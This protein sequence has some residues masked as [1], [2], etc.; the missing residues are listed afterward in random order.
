MQ[1]TT[2]LSDRG[3]RAGGSRELPPDL[4]QPAESTESKPRMCTFTRRVAFGETQIVRGKRPC[5]QN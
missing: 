2:Q 3:Y 1:L 4:D 5:R